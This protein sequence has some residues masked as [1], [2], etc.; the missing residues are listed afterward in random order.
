MWDIWLGTWAKHWSLWFHN[1]HSDH[2]ATSPTLYWFFK[3]VFTNNS[4]QWRSRGKTKILGRKEGLRAFPWGGRTVCMCVNFSFLCQTQ[5]CGWGDQ[6]KKRI[7]KSDDGCVLWQPDG[8][9]NKKDNKNKWDSLP[10]GWTSGA[11]QEWNPSLSQEDSDPQ[12]KW[13]CKRGHT[14]FSY[15][16]NCWFF[17]PKQSTWNFSI[18]TIKML[19]LSHKHPGRGSLQIL[20]FYL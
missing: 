13:L 11:S 19:G 14:Y 4:Q 7:Q 15:N 5:T 17:F 9:Q 18:K 3:I 16:Q 10:N 2:S 1:K 8:S 12:C 6:R 20:H